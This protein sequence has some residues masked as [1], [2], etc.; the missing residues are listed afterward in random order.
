MR[1]NKNNFSGKNEEDEDNS[2]SLVKVPT[3]EDVRGKRNKRKKDK[4][5]Q[6]KYGDSYDDW[7]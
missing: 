4:D 1:P 2:S 3:K 5:Y 7:N 6:K